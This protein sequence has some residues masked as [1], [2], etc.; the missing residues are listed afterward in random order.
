MPGDSFRFDPA[1]FVLP[2]HAPLGVDQPF[3]L[4]N[5][6]QSAWSRF[7]WGQ[8]AV[9]FLDD[10]FLA[11]RDF[12]EVL[13]SRATFVNGPL[14]QFYRFF[15][16][17]TCCGP[18]QEL[19]YT[20][21]EPLVEPYQLPGALPPQDTDTWLRVGDRGPHAAGILTMPVFLAVRMP[22]RCRRRTPTRGCASAIA[23][24][25]PPAS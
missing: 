18:A 10:L 6:P 8:E 24:R 3:E 21:P 2:T 1:A 12:R 17:A 5:Q 25:T 19:D 4:R 13:T 9:R 7:W 23:A 14:A 15:A 16:P 22:A 11:D 20:Q